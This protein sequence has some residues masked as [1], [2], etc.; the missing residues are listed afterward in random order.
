MMAAAVSAALI[1]P[2]TVLAETPAE[3]KEAQYKAAQQD[4]K[5]TD[6]QTLVIKYS[7]ALP[8]SVHKKAG[9]AIIK[10]L[11]SLGYDVV[12][13]PKSKKLSDVLDVYKTRS[14]IVAMTPSVQ[15]KRLAATSD[16]KKSKMDH[17]ALLNMDK[18]LQYAGKND[19]TIAVVDGGVDYKHPEL[20]ANLLAPYNAVK[21]ARNPV[22]DLH[23]T[24][25]AGIIASVKDNGLGGHGVFPNAKILP[26]DVFNGSIGAN[27]Y[28]IADGIVYSVDKGADV[29]N[30]S[31][32]D[33]MPSPLIQEAVQY[34]I[35]SGTVVVAAAG[36]A[37]TDTSM[38]PAAYPG[39]ISVGNVDGGKKL[40][41]SSNYGASVDVVAPGENIY[42][43][44]YG[45]ESG[46]KFDRL[47][48]TSMASPMV[49]ATA[50][51]LKSK[52]PELTAFE[53]EYILEKTATDLG[54]KG[55]DLTYGNGLINPL[56]ALTFDISQLPARP[57]ESGE[58]LLQTA[59]EVISGKQ[60]FT[61]SFTSPGAMH[62]YKVNLAEGE[63]VQTVLNGS[64]RYDYAME[65]YFAP[66]NGELEYVR[67]VDATRVGKQEGNLY[68]A[69]ELGTLLIGVKDSNGNYS[70][71]GKSS[72][73]LMAEKVE[74]ITPDATSEENPIT[75]TS[76][77]F[78]K[79]DFTM[80]TN[81][82]EAP[83]TDYFT[84]S[85]EEPKLLS[86]S[87]S[88]LPGVDSAVSA[89]IIEESEEE[90]GYYEIAYTNNGA[91]NEGETLSFQAVPGVDYHINV[92]NA[93]F[94]NDL[95]GG[96]L[97]D[98]LSMDIDEMNGGAYR[99][100]AYPYTM[101]VEEREIPADEDGLPKE[102]TLEDALLNKKISPS[103]Y[104][105]IKEDSLINEK[106]GEDNYDAIIMEKAL[107]YT[108]GQDKSGYFQMEYDEDYYRLTPSVDGIYQFS[109]NEGNSQL[110]SMTFMEYDEETKSLVPVYDS[111]GE[112]G[113][114][115]GLL[116]G[117][118]RSPELNIALKKGTT[119]VIQL[120]NNLYNISVDPYVLKSKKVANVPAEM[121]ND[122]NVPEEGLDIKAGK[123]YKNYFVQAGDID[124]Y[125]FMNNGKARVHT[126]DIT[127]SALTAIQKVSI[128]YELRQEHIFSGAIVED[129]NGD[130]VMDPDEMRQAAVFGPDLLSF[131]IEPEVNTSFAAK[132][133]TGYF[134]EV[135]SF[136]PTG[137]SLQP[138]E[139]KVGATFNQFADGDAKVV[140]HVPTKPLPLKTVNGKYGAR[141]YFNAGVPFGDTDHF[142]LNMMKEGTVS[143]SLTAGQNL[144]GVV[145]VYNEKGKLV[146]A[147]DRY[148]QNDE[149]IGTLKLAKGKYFIEL[150]EANGTASTAPYELIV[151]K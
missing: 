16:P 75:I 145:E 99:S 70:E 85:V 132:E 119:Y 30:L 50:G 83:D 13:I 98:L 40:S 127:S 58:E 93:T 94:S 4:Q 146:A 86:V 142:L 64:H 65:L 71:S 72:F 9:V 15:Y 82:E 29:I 1:I 49:A 3:Q 124:Y 60:T 54:E 10:R 133:E 89:S 121:D 79:H 51:L 76:L 11:P 6:S 135:N 73:T 108:I 32:G 67:D 92:T 69:A 8:K 42:S 122:Q 129:T 17:L 97:L 138:Y 55:Y 112:M 66:E 123:S 20:K 27:D 141:G 101:N 104:G 36:N 139:I 128:P 12:H 68:T 56:N 44:A 43:T 63:H 24:H 110:A 90:R 78:V 116:D 41:D 23:G 35:D 81:E 59:E 103:E 130:K 125:Y 47:T 74:P 140:N 106:E 151:K 39:V 62:W 14:E 109:I 80:Y 131:I 25:V 149:E 53:I 136:L 115:M 126:L 22:R 150:S 28:T 18:A 5:M 113:L 91:T 21:P 137:P 84:L 100:S 134:I 52:Y 46:S 7:K 57:E 148:G 143:L 26:V 111:G 45:S 48:G 2:G 105:E 114:M 118:G 147:F 87:I 31:L 117:K 34:A 102:D 120:T 77:P 37:S 61:G 38:Y 144:D 95:F 33:Y 19:V 96:S 88:G 107:P